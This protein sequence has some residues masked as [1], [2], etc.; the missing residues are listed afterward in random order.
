MEAAAFGGLIPGVRRFS[1]VMS[2]CIRAE[3]FEEG[4]YVMK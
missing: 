4:N 2:R 1:E 3:E